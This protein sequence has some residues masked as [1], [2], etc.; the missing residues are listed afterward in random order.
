M[1]KILSVLI[2]GATA[3]CAGGE[4]A[5]ET[6]KVAWGRD[7][8]TAL[9][10][11]AS[12]GKPI[13]ALFQEVPGC[14][15]CKQFGKEVL[16]TPLLVDAIE[17]EFVPLLIHNNQQGKD[18]ELLKRFK[19]PAWNYQ[20][21]RFLDS[22]AK[23]LIPRKDKVWTTGPLA[24][25]MIAS[26]NRADREVPAYLSLLRDEHAAEFK[27]VAFAMPCFWTGEARLGAIDGVV[28]TEAGWIGRK[29]VTLLTYLPSRIPLADL[30]RKAEAIQCAHAVFLPAGEGRHMDFGKLTPLVLSNYRKA[31]DSDQKKQIQGTSVAKL[32]LTGAQATKVNAWIRTDPRKA[33]SFLSPQQAEQVTRP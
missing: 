20:V 5:V 8:D 17:A 19:E 13:F 23:D 22:D 9:K 16:S 27:R 1:N 33:M 7:L 29:E 32:G 3:A 15:G 28:S 30:V 6:G 18:A 25:R 2:A 12:S 26:L 4:H 31:K 11:S 14:A 21:V 10:S 24:D